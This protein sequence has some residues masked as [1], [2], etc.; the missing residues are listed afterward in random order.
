MLFLSLFPLPVVNMDVGPCK[1]DILF[2]KYVP[3]IQ[4]M[5]FFSLDFE[6]FNNCLDVSRSWKELF[7]S[8]SYLKKAKS[9]FHGEIV[10]DE[11]ELHKKLCQAAKDG[12]VDEVRILS[13]FADV[14][15]SYNTKP[16]SCHRTTTPLC[17]AASVPSK[18]VSHKNV[19]KLLLERGADPN[20]ATSSGWTPLHWAAQDG[21][22]EV[23]QLLLDGDANPNSDNSD[24]LTPLHETAWRGYKDMVQLLLNTGA[25][26]NKAT[27]SGSTPLFL[28]RKFGHMDIVNILNDALKLQ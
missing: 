8:E 1:F 6:T 25:D 22:K 2:T 7:T 20:V 24:G 17:E 19:I 12:N 3:H 13:V 18:Q 10:R 28:A 15:F 27:R 11:E 23:M 4:E 14:N 5:I 21:N 16:F 9:V 26:P